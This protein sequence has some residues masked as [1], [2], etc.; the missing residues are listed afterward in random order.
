MTDIT[1][2]N[3]VLK[4]ACDILRD[5]EDVSPDQLAAELL[6][7]PA[8][9]KGRKADLG[10][11]EAMEQIYLAR[12]AFKD[13]ANHSIVVVSALLTVAGLLIYGAIGSSLVRD[14]TSFSWPASGLLAVVAVSVVEGALLVVSNYAQQLRAGY[15]L[16][17]GAC[18]MGAAM[19]IARYRSV[20][21]TWHSDAL[22]CGQQKAWFFRG[23][24]DSS[25]QSDIVAVFAGSTTTLQE[26][27]QRCEC[28]VDDNVVVQRPRFHLSSEGLV[29]DDVAVHARLPKTVAEVA[30]IWSCSRRTTLSIHLS[31][32]GLVALFLGAF[33]WLGWA[34]L[35]LAL[36]KSWQTLS[37]SVYALTGVSL[38]TA[39]SDTFPLYIC[40]VAA[41]LALRWNF[42]GARWSAGLPR[43]LEREP[44]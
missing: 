29:V 21:H 24:R 17:A 23:R 19:W 28:L 18:V 11:G 16:Y 25:W 7:A 10:A 13:D 1:K 44:G 22:I 37:G 36:A 33:T 2:E 15:S 42:R 43:L 34:Y 41:A 26:A 40:T 35:G 30:A 32:L 8:K 5:Q 27:V 39:E 9:S 12:Q 4:V 20:A 31:N 38:R 6:G 14:N 3:A